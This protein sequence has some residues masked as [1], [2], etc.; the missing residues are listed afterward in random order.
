MPFSSPE[1]RAKWRAAN[2]EKLRA[3]DREYQK[4]RKRDVTEK[5]ASDRRHYEATRERRLAYQREYSKRY[6]ETKRRAAGKRPRPDLSH[7]SAKEKRA[8]RA[9]YERQRSAKAMAFDPGNVTPLLRQ[10]MSVRILHPLRPK[11][12]RPL[13]SATT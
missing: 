5:A 11:D 13:C 9:E 2:R 6:K 7:L 12:T 3:Y 4:R 8:H 1:Y 10:F